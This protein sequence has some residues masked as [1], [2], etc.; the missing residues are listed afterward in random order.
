[1][2]NIPLNQMGYSQLVGSMTGTLISKTGIAKIHVG[3]PILSIIE[4]VA[5]SQLR[6][7]ADIFTLL[8]SVSLDTATGDALQ[9]IGNDENVPILDARA[10]GGYVTLLDTSFAKIAS[11]LYPG[12]AAPIAG[13]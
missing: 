3:N 7:S 11:T 10:A 1:M 12:L 8:A 2:A 9:R 5:M 6:V 4:S 13:S